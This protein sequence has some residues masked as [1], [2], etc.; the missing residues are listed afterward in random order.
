MTFIRNLVFF[1]IKHCL[2][3][4]YSQ[5]HAHPLC[6][7]FRCYISFAHNVNYVFF[8]RFL[9][10]Y[11]LL[12]CCY[13]FYCKCYLFFASQ[14]TKSFFLFLLSNGSILT[15]TTFSLHRLVRIYTYKFV[16]LCAKCCVDTATAK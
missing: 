13:L 6:F 4:C 7:F 15:L 5:P 2:C 14:I 3:L 12:Y 10:F 11:I 1:L 8:R 16:F 9:T